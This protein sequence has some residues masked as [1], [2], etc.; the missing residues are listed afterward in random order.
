MFGSGRKRALAIVALGLTLCAFLAYYVLW[1]VTIP[2]PVASTAGVAG[3]PVRLTPQTVG[4]H[5]PVIPTSQV[6]FL[7][8][9]PEVLLWSNRPKSRDGG[10]GAS[11]PRR[12]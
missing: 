11:C 4:N 5:H 9:A 12:G 2:Q 3:S 10:Y 6:R 1:L 8:G 7:T